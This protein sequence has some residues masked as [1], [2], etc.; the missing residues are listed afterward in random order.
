MP[1]M[2]CGTSEYQLS[3]FDAFNRLYKDKYEIYLYVNHEADEYHNLSTKYDNVLHPETITGT[4]HLGYAPNQLV[5]YEPQPYM[6]RHCLKI[7]QTM[8]DIMMVRIDEHTKSDV[9]CFVEL[10]IKLCDGIVFISNFSKKDFLAYFVNDNSI[11]DKQLKVIYP[12]AGFNKPTKEYDLPFEKYFLI[13]GNS[14]KHKAINETLKA[15]STT[16]HNYLIVGYGDGNYILPNIYGYK[17][18]DLDDEFLSYLYS[19]CEAVIFPSMYEGFGFP[20]VNS[21]INKK[22]IILKNNALNNELIDR[23]HDFK[24]FFTLF[25]KFEE[26]RDIVE[27][28]DLLIEVEHCGLYDTWDR[29]AEELEVFFGLILKTETNADKLNERWDLFKMVEANSIINEPQIKSLNEENL[30]QH[31]HI[32][33]LT[34]AYN[35]IYNNKKLSSLLSFTIKTYIRNKIPG[36]HQVIKKLGKKT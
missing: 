11:K 1:A 25:E 8:F 32:E 16:Q 12:A 23:F 30:K 22:R 20:V 5:F 21:I 4:F 26:I 14:Y 17:S 33:E 28:T 6:N 29:A 10:G 2:H 27:N 36:L 34:H 18:G 24:D 9:N 19:K 15:I 3:V 35:E 13:I 7:V 31:K